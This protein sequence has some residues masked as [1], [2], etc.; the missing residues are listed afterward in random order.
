MGIK[1]SREHNHFV[2][3]YHR[4]HPVT[5]QTKTIRRQGI[6]T[7][8]EA[9]KIYKKLII[10][11]GEKINEVL[12]PYWPDVVG[13]FLISFMNRGIANNTLINYR[14]T[15]KAHTYPKWEKKHINEIST[16]EIRD[17][18]M[19]DMSVYSESHK[20]SM[21]KHIRAVFQ[22]AHDSEIID[23]NPTPKLK[24][25]VGEKIKLVLKENEVKTL[26]KKAKDLNNRWFPIWALACFTG[27][28]NG[29]LFALKW[30]KVDL[31]K[32][33]TQ[34]VAEILGIGAV[35]YN[36]LSQ[37]RMSDIVFDWN[38]MLSFDGNSAPYLQ[39]TY[40]RLKSILRKAKGVPKLNNT[41]I[42]GERDLALA[43]KLSEFPDVLGRVKETYM[44]SQLAGYLYE[45]AKEVNS[46]S[47]S[48]PVLYSEEE[49]RTVRLN[50]VKAAS[51]VLRTGLGLLGIHTVEKM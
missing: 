11:M 14:T 8:E 24:F 6:K 48:E 41:T 9:E 38:K 25:K 17:L 44:P 34:E 42:E 16:T 19:E 27:M 18:I 29:E 5:K 39:Y 20:K 33:E 50:L 35:K 43:L 47:H 51:N 30:S 40:A 4:R 10:L 2:V 46:Y 1:Y 45:L 7:R 3:S 12:Y 23:R 28:R 13:E 15:L 32:S 26:L 21:L 31:K 37:N 49:L 36:D 22:F